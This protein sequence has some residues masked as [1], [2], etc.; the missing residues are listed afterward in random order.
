MDSSPQSAKHPQSAKLVNAG[1]I[2]ENPDSSMPRP[3]APMQIPIPESQLLNPRTAEIRPA[4][5]PL[6][7]PSAL[8]ATD[9]YAAPN[10]YRMLAALSVSH[11]FNDFCMG[12]AAPM[13]PTLET[14]F[15]LTLGGVASIL[16]VTS[17]VSNFTQ[18]V[19][20]WIMERSRTA[21][22][23]LF[24]PFLCALTFLLGFTDS[25]W[26]ARALFFAAGIANGA[27]HPFSYILAQIA[28]PRRPALS[29]AIFISFG[30]L[31]V[32]SGAMISG[33]WMEHWKFAG[34]H[35]LYLG[36][37]A[38]AAALLVRR[39]QSVELA[40]YLAFVRP[41][42]RGGAAS[43][44]EAADESRRVPFAI[45]W[46]AGFLMAL[47]GGTIMFFTPKLFKVL[48]GSEG[49]GGDACFLYGIIGGVCSYYYAHRADRR[50]PFKV[51]ML[52]QLAAI[53]PFLGL[54]YF[55]SSAAKIAMIALIGASAGATLPVMTS[56]ARPSRGLT[57]GL[58][59]SLML[60]GTW[61]VVAIVHF[62]MAQLADRVGLENVMSAVCAA[63]AVCAMVLAAAH[64][65]YFP[66]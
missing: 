60:G 39:I 24:C 44:G 32:S 11:F 53:L 62:T 59:T 65:K 36:A 42:R 12:I 28:L 21:I 6:S 50:D 26:Q 27:F 16:I 14:K 51:V 33:H 22:M 18:P 49:L 38:T 7:D 20:G 41:P 23:L 9:L 29:T 1:K 64:R 13:I 48:Y 2:G 4:T 3:P 66:A 47:E 56:M 15:S 25:P 46:I 19:A 54:F 52:V 40:P 5:L 17:L 63:P 8:P 31:G 10:D 45:V 57:V 43:N 35:W 55:D 30:F 61:G 58:R 37:F 34:F